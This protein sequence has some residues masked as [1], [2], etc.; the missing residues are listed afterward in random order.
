[1]PVFNFLHWTNEHGNTLAETGPLVAVEVGVPAALREYLTEQR[2]TVP[3]SISGFALVD[4]GAYATAVDE[5]IFASLNVP[6]IDEIPTSTTHGNQ[7]SKVYP[8]S[9]SFPALNVTDFPMERVI[10]SNLKWQTRDGREIIMLLGRDV[11]QY[12][13]MVYNGPRSDITLCY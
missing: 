8:A 6:H 5:S 11:L 13:L 7:M 9:L 12:F 3:A 4:T 10:G 1:M 2:T